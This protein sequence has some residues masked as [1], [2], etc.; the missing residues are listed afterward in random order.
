MTRGE[1]CVTRRSRE[2]PAAVR[3]GRM[4]RDAVRNFALRDWRAV[5]DAK[6]DYWAERLRREG[7]ETLVAVAEDL[8][9][10]VRSVRPEWP[11]PADRRADLRHHVRLKRRLEAAC[12]AF[13]RR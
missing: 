9:R 7:T 5:E 2:R 8:R 1:A 12:D 10:L 3:L 13:V 11:T 6:R 4:D